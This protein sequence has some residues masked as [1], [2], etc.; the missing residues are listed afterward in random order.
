MI[1]W[2]LENLNTKDAQFILITRED[3]LDAEKVVVSELSLKYKIKWIA[4]NEKTEG[5]VCTVLKAK[6]LIDNESPLVI[7]NSDQFVEF[8]FNTFIE[9]AVKRD[10]DGSIL[11]FTDTNPKWSFAK[12]ENE[13]VSR[14]E[15][16]NPISDIATVGV[17]F[18]KTGSDYVQGA[19]EM[20]RADERVNN[21][22]YNCPVYNYLI[23]KSKKIGNFHIDESQMHGLGTPDD[24]SAFIKAYSKD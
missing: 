23:Q 11:T 22:F 9:D 12:V 17:Y 1:S 18:F 21:E 7:A 20:I 5:S 15:E 13:L 3:H 8:S 14:V 2:V 16:K 4:I 19:E 6:D 24:L 10:L